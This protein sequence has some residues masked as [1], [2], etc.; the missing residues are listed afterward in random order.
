MLIN[1]E[2]TERKPR[3]AKTKQDWEK[4]EAIRNSMFEAIKQI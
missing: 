1:E 2:V 3:Q 4:E